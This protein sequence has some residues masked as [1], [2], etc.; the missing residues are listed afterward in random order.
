MTFRGV[1][2]LFLS[3]EPVAESVEYVVTYEPPQQFRLGRIY[4][5]LPL[6]QFEGLSPM[7]LPG[8]NGPRADL[9]LRLDDG[10]L[11]NATCRAQTVRSPAVEGSSRNCS[12]KRRACPLTAPP[13]RPVARRTRF[14]ATRLTHHDAR[15]PI[16]QA[17]PNPSGIARSHLRQWSSMVDSRPSHTEYRRDAIQSQTAAPSG[18]VPSRTAIII[19]NASS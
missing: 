8:L 15:P 9:A 12:R 19:S 3:G 6:D 2:S 11:G 5:R 14:A 17:S 7:S 13:R 16:R 18:I 4:G 10:R 1:G